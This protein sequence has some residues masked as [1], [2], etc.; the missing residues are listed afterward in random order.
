MKYLITIICIILIYISL[1]CY[2]I[3]KICINSINPYIERVINYEIERQA[4]D[5]LY[6]EILRQLKERGI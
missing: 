4:S 5:E 2:V 6:N 3:P 1:V